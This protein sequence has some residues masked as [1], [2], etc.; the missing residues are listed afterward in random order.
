MPTP[1]PFA[2][3]IGG[4]YLAISPVIDAERSMNLF[5]EKPAGQAKAFPALIQRPGLTTRWNLGGL[6]PTALFTIFTPIYESVTYVLSESGLYQIDFGSSSVATLGT[7][8]STAGDPY[9]QSSIAASQTQVLVGKGTHGYIWDYSTA[10]LTPI[11]S[12][13]WPPPLAGVASVTQIDGYFIALND[14]NTLGSSNLND[15]L[16]WN[17]L[18]YALV[19]SPDAAIRIITD[20]HNLLWIFCAEHVEVWSDQAISPGFPFAPLSGAKMQV[21]CRAALS[22]CLLDNTIFWI[23]SDTRGISGVYRASGFSP[24]R[25]STP[26]I[27]LLISGI[28]ANDIRLAE[29]MTY[30]EN[31]H[32]FYQ[33]SIPQSGLCICYDVSTGQWADRSRYHDGNFIQHSAV[34]HTYNET[35]NIHVVAG[36]TTDSIYEQSTSILKD[37]DDVIYRYRAAPVIWDSSLTI[38]FYQLLLDAAAG[39]GLPDGSASYVR[40]EMSNDGGQTWFGGLPAYLGAVGDYT[41]RAQWTMLGSARKRCFRISQMDEAP[42]YWVGVYLNMAE[43]IN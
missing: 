40:L 43:G 24:E 16:T 13:G 22:V 39:I 28:S 31:G 30:Y 42:T 26:A 11:S 32:A 1:V 10:T 8:A 4:S 3:F 29:S 17:A 41:A 38:K 23:G 18:N 2:G 36:F 14:A 7:L 34:R 35:F 33:I 6:N 25:I 12:A 9:N 19:N 37:D 20:G 5:V 15:G 27:D 21:G